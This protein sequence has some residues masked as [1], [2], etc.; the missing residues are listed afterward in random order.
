MPRRKK[1]YKPEIVNPEDVTLALKN[2]AMMARNFLE[3]RVQAA[4]VNKDGSASEHKQK[5]F[6]ARSKQ[7]LR[8]ITKM[9]YTELAAYTDTDGVTPPALL[10]EELCL[11]FLASALLIHLTKVEGKKV[12]PESLFE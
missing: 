6:R 11:S 1:T 2:A 5:H 4:L 9:Y 8:E 10:A 12:D 7:S 3:Q